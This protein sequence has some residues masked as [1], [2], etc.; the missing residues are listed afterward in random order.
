ME[1]TDE[2]ATCENCDMT[3]V[4]LDRGHCEGCICLCCKRT[5]AEY[6]LKIAEIVGGEPMRQLADFYISNTL[7]DGMDVQMILKQLSENPETRTELVSLIHAA[8]DNTLEG[9]AL[10][11]ARCGAKRMTALRDRDFVAFAKRVRDTIT[12]EKSVAGAAR[13]LGVSRGHMYRY[14]R[15]VRDYDR[16]R[17]QAKGLTLGVA[18]EEPKDS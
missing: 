16:A 17:E 13:A 14:A 9:W 8:T 12:K 3:D 6:I 5:A 1:A 18:D 7:P 2:P 11:H 10:A 4:P 15:Q